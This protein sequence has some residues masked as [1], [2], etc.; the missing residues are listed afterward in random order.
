MARY[1]NEDL[2]R[3]ILR[4][5]QKINKILEILE[6]MKDEIKTLGD[7]IDEKNN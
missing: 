1:T 7:K 6:D 2:E 4:M 5:T 3:E